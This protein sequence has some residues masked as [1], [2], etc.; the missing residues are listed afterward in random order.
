MLD[1]C[2]GK[3]DRN[4]ETGDASDSSGSQLLAILERRRSVTPLR[5]AEPGPSARE[6][7][8]LLAIA[9]RV[10]DHG[11]L[12][13]WRI[14][15]LQGSARQ[16]L[17]KRLEA[18]FLQANGQLDAADAELRLRK[19]KAVLTAPLIVI[20]VS[21]VDASAR[22]P[23]WEQLLSAGAVCMNL[24]TAATALGYGS[25]W[26]TGWTAYDPAARKV[27]G[28]APDEKVAGIIPIGTPTDLPV[29]RSRPSLQYLVTTWSP[30]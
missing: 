9:M 19:I 20:V 18:A 15:L 12:E 28:I 17:S 24:M 7:Q 27:L 14:V 13:P 16:A 21:C 2:D 6:L 29:D 1:N 30:A 5:L 8:R 26:L 23:E 3:I 25:N 4:T 22:V 11:A 10:P